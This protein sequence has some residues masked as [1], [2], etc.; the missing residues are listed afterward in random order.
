[1]RFL[2]VFYLTLGLMLPATLTVSVVAAE[3][4]AFTSNECVA[5]EWSARM[6][7]RQGYLVNDSYMCWDLNYQQT[8]ADVNFSKNVI[9]FQGR[10]YFLR[11]LNTTEVMTNIGFPTATRM[12]PLSD[13]IYLS[14]HYNL[15][16]TADE[17]VYIL[18]DSGLAEVNYLVPYGKN[19]IY[20]RYLS[21]NIG[22]EYF[23]RIQMFKPDNE[24]L[25]FEAW[26]V[27]PSKIGDG[28]TFT[29]QEALEGLDDEG[30]KGLEF[31]EQEVMGLV[32]DDDETM[33]LACAANHASC[34]LA[35]QPTNA[36]IFLDI[37]SEQDAVE[38]FQK[39]LAEQ[40][41]PIQSN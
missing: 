13:S 36:R 14:N 18:P 12:R 9:E 20:V 17:K 39:Q 30:D 25:S 35:V 28:L 31:T 38:A 3:S 1:M 27:D 2:N 5:L 37:D 11:N 21:L 6:L 34:N 19:L 22:I 26:E 8:H 32:R 10:K 41:K 4:K 33:L 29:E 24:G 23:I 16:E 7:T 40:N 15:A